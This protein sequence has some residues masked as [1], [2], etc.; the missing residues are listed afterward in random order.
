MCG[1]SDALFAA[2]SAFK[3]EGFKAFA[4]VDAAGAAGEYAHFGCRNVVQ[5]VPG[6]FFYALVSGYSAY[7]DFSAGLEGFPQAVIQAFEG[8]VLLSSLFASF[9]V[10]YGSFAFGR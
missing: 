3:Y 8:P 10:E 7:V 4:R 6:A 2:Y 9:E 5:K 1:F